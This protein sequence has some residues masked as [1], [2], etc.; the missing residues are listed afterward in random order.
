[1]LGWVDS[2][3]VK[4]WW[5][6]KWRHKPNH[7]ANKC[8]LLICSIAR[9]IFHWYLNLQTNIFVC[10][11]LCSRD[12]ESICQP[13]KYQPIK[14][15]RAT[16]A[17]HCACGCFAVLRNRQRTALNIKVFMFWSSYM[18][19]FRYSSEIS[20]HFKKDRWPLDRHYL[21]LHKR[22]S[23][24]TTIMEF[25]RGWMGIN[26]CCRCNL[27]I[28]PL[29][30]FLSKPI[31]TSKQKEFDN[32]NWYKM[33]LVFGD[34]IFNLLIHFPWAYELNGACVCVCGAGGGGGG[35]G[36]GGRG[37]QGGSITKL[38]KNEWWVSLYVMCVY[39]CKHIKVL[40]VRHLTFT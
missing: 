2:N 29:H 37:G 19:T 9:N 17:N 20:Q 14:Y 28:D 22:W 3:W 18:I 1:M 25:Q 21:P 39:V 30:F 7:C 5:Q 15:K 40:G 26:A 6:S 10:V 23:I 35:G 4:T 12:S 33:R 34:N 8:W 27:Q 16:F 36:G 24:Y 32:D 13:Y 31:L 38:T 11:W